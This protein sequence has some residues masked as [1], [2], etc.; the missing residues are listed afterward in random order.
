MLKEEL[1]SVFNKYKNDYDIYHELTPFHV[2]EIL[3]VTSL[4]DAFILEEEERINENLFGQYSDLELTTAPRIT[5]ASDDSEAI[6]FLQQRYFD[7]AIVTIRTQQLTPFELADKLKSIKPDLPIFLLLYDNSDLA[8][9]N[10]MSEKLNIFEKV[11]VWNRDSRIFLAIAKY[12]EDKMNVEN[13]TKVGLV[14]VILLVEN[15]VRYYSKYL[16]ILYQE[17]IKQTQRL[18]TQDNLDPV[19]KNLRMRARPKVLMAL[20]YEEA[21]EIFERY[22]EY[23]LCV[24]SDVKFPRKG[25]IDDEAGI[26]L[27]HAVKALE[28]DI[29]YVL[30]SS[31]AEFEKTAISLETAFINKNSDSLANDLTKFIRQNLG[32]GDFVFRDESGAEIERAHSI[33]E[34]KDMLSIVPSETIMYH[35]RRNHFSAWL[36]ARGE[37]QIAEH[38]Q[39]LK[40]SDFKGPEEIRDYI[41]KSTRTIESTIARG[42]VVDFDEDLIGVDNLIL[43]LAKGSFGGKG[44]G[45]AFINSIIQNTELFKELNIPVR[46]P[47]TAFIGAEEYINFIESNNLINIIKDTNYG[48]LKK[49]FLDAKLSDDLIEKL[50]VYLGYVRVPLAVRSSG[51]YEDSISESFSGVFNTYLIPNKHPEMKERLKNL[52][53]AIKLVYA[54][55]FSGISHSYFDA[56]NY[57]IEDEKMSVVIQEIVGEKFGNIFFPHISGVALSY[58]FYPIQ[59]FKPEDGICVAAAGLGKY[60]IDGEKSY[61]FC[62]KFPKIDIN[63]PEAQFKNSQTF[64]YAIDME[65]SSYNLLENED[66]TLKTVNIKDVETLEAIEDIVSVWDKQDNKLKPG[67]SADGPRI[68]NFF[69]ILKYDS[70]PL[71]KVLKYLLELFENSMGLPVEIEFA[72]NLN[73]DNPAF[74]I[75][76]I[77]PLIRD[78]SFFTFEADEIKKSDMM[79]YTEQGMGNGKIENIKDIIFIDPELFNKAETLEMS[80][81]IQ[82]LN[83]K[84]HR[85][86]D[87]YILIGPGRWGTRDR[88]LGIPVQWTQISN[89]KIIVET[90]LKD[91]RVDASLGSHFFHN[92]T[93]MNIGY[94]TVHES[95]GRDF[96]DW[97]WLKNLHTVDMTKHFIHVE[98]EKPV[99]ILMDGKRSI[100]IIRK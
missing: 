63:E 38:L 93:T 13:D 9:I 34:F 67:L 89:A 6:S 66:I 62:P 39:P 8:L 30:Q 60:V 99:L 44:R 76:Q 37:I 24:I 83:D 97:Q 69:P 57:K 25:E 56:I 92:I 79:L 65:K 71:A 5:N 70:F 87:N 53:D 64:L 75:L 17:I 4:Y 1:K 3:L 18:I 42:G 100:S 49:K 90:D 12:F 7:Y 48:E 33:A 46:I 98:T 21:I 14:R 84:M 28:S 91:F 54:S 20:S 58:N 26:K 85:F 43:R 74:Y 61:R 80:Q 10:R 88:W 16:P 31:D 35:G 81:E 41:I 77:K 55:T 36:M 2:R 86:G 73:P 29:P 32:F 40:V 50:K 27:L 51:M 78:T 47:K 68:I 95:N 45:I 23:L 22:R 94:F 82:E 72:V 11:F 19:K 15:S 96:I 52:M 59:R